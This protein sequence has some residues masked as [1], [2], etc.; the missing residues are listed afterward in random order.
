MQETKIKAARQNDVWFDDGRDFDFNEG[1][2][3][4]YDEYNDFD[5][6]AGMNSN[7]FRRVVQ[8]MEKEWL[9]SNK[10]KSAVHVVSTNRLSAA[11]VK[12]IVM[13]FGFENNKLEVAK[14]AY[15]NTID[16]RNY[17]IIYDVLTFSNS[18]T[19]LDRYIRTS[20]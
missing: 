18:R 20:R 10:L 5:A 13:L 15:R 14:Q 16:K 6:G 3:G 7:E 9:E 17:S 2:Y 8:S 4:G 12:E 11:Q 19:E 1:Q